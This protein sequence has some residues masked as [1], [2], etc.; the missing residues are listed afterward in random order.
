MESG[1]RCV[2]K[3]WLCTGGDKA[4]FQELHEAYEKIME[5]RR[6]TLARTFSA[7]LRIS[8]MESDAQTGNVP[9]TALTFE[10]I[11]PTSSVCH[12][13]PGSANLDGKSRD[14]AASRCFRVAS[15]P[16]QVAEQL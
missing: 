7:E 1:G 4:E 9:D 10:T 15:Y 16:D 2:R 12:H 8:A 11:G 14:S 3:K 6:S 5:Q 13:R